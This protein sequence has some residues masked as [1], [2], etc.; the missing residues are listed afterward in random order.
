M[1]SV[2]LRLSELEAHVPMAALFS[3][4]PRLHVRRAR[5]EV[6]RPVLRAALKALELEWVTVREFVDDDPPRVVL[7]VDLWDYAPNVTV[8][9]ALQV[10]RTGKLRVDVESVTAI[11]PLPRKTAAAL[12]RSQL[13]GVSGLRLGNGATVVHV[14]VERLGG[15]MGVGLPPASEVTASARALALTFED[16]GP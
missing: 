10:T 4:E 11:V 5:L 2:G 14:D 1:S 15:L 3:D 7:D 13:P 16:A 8:T 9:L 12:I 6:T